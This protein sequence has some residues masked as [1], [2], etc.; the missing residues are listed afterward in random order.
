MQIPAVGAKFYGPV[1]A[2]IPVRVMYWKE[3]EECT[4]LSLYGEVAF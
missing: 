4:I 2:Y 3:V 1:L